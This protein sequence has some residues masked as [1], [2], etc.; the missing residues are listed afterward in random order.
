M[1]LIAADDRPRRSSSASPRARLTLL[2][3]SQATGSVI[4][5]AGLVTLIVLL[6]LIGVL[7]LNIAMSQGS[8]ERSALA[9]ESGRLAQEEQ[10]LQETQERLST[11]QELERRARALGMVPSGD[12]AFIDLSDGSIVGEA[13]P[14]GV[15][16][17][18]AITVPTASVYDAGAVPPT[19]PSGN[20][21]QT[22]AGHTTQGQ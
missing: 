10:A 7:A 6:T 2:A 19:T 4:P 20:R 8:Y 15:D 16:P 14:A 11:P 1:A 18:V 17:G 3:P 13:Q 5:F 21:P 12:P 9:A 22:T